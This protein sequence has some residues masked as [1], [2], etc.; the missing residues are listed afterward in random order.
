LPVPSHWRTSVGSGERSSACTR[1]I[2]ASSGM[3]ATSSCA[4]DRGLL[5]LNLRRVGEGVPMDSRM[6][7]APLGNVHI[8]CPSPFHAGR[9]GI[10]G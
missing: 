10:C 6:I 9:S 1:S 2:V 5:A 7:C 3:F 8:P 4:I